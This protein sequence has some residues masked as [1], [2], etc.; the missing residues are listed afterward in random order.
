MAMPDDY[1]PPADEEP[2]RAV[3]GESYWIDGATEDTTAATSA[4][5]DRPSVPLWKLELQFIVGGERGEQLYRTSDAAAYVRTLWDEMEDQVRGRATFHEAFSEFVQEWQPSA[6]ERASALYDILSLIGGFT[7]P[8]GYTK[9]AGYLTYGD[10]SHLSA[11]PHAN[12]D[13]EIDLQV[14]A[15]VTLRNYFRIAPLDEANSAYQTY[16]RLLRNHLTRRRYFGF[17]ASQLLE[18]GQLETDAASFVDGIRLWPESLREIIPG[19]LTPYHRE[20]ASR[21]LGRVY[22]YCRKNGAEWFGLFEEIIRECGGVLSRDHQVVGGGGRREDIFWEP[23]P[24][25]V[26]ED[27]SEIEI[28]LSTEQMVSYVEAREPSALP[29]VRADVLAEQGQ[30]IADSVRL[31]EGYIVHYINTHLKGGHGIAWSPLRDELHVKGIQLMC[32]RETGR[33][34]V[35]FKAINQSVPLKLPEHTFEVLLSA[36]YSP[37]HVTPEQLLARTVSP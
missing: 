26:L 36:Y 19:L 21:D 23:E 15:L 8:A 28:N 12:P 17:A 29:P 27:G 32:S 13:V 30:H 31:V 22:A 33:A 10:W 16:L 7:P 6:G 3:D 14:K 4:L 9:I 1:V 20:A 5:I 35:Y 24:V 18:L 37:Q 2:G 11:T 34:Y 25:V